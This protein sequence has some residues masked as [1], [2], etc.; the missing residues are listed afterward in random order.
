V[1]GWLRPDGT[2]DRARV[3]EVI[4]SD[5]EKR[6][7]LNSTLHPLIIAEQ[8][9][10]MRR[11]ELGDPRDIG[12]VDA[13]L[14]IESGGHKRFDR[15][16]VVH[17]RPEVQLERLMRRNGLPR[18]EAE[19]RIAAQMPQSEKL[20]HADFR[21]DTSEGFEDTRRQTAAV[22]AELRRLADESAPGGTSDS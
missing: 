4:F 15:L 22:Y 7:L 6:E 17:C 18:E 13:A 16:V 8:D 19:R 12:V 3:S 21:I 11:W 9:E 20:R 10:L 5:A 1:S 2:L 14:L